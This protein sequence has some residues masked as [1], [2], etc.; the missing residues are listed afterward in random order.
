MNIQATLPTGV[1][2]ITVHG[3]HQWDYGRKIEIKAAALSGQAVVEVH[4]AYAG[5]T[6]AVVRTCSVSA[7][8]VTAAIPDECLEQTAPVLA[9][10]FCPT[11][12]EGFTILKVTM[13][14][15]PKT[16]PASLPTNPPS[17]YSNQY[18]QLIKAANDLLANTYTKS[19]IQAALG[20]YITDVDA[21]I[22]GGV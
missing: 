18:T 8:T 21:L 11:S 12:T 16:K 22:G 15:N 17:D 14:V 20:V 6:E 1:T 13:P 7:L 2:E 10:V 5:L 19:E 4:F 9:W 3:L